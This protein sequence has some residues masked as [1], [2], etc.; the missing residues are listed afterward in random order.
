MNKKSSDNAFRRIPTEEAF[1]VP[2]QMDA[3]RKV[4]AEASDYHPDLYL[5]S[6]TLGGGVIHDRLLDLDGER[7]NIMD[8][9][10]I[11]MQLLSLTSTGV[12]MMDADTANAVA[13]TANDQLADAIGRHPG[14]YAGLATVAPQSPQAAAK[15]V[16]RA[17]SELNLNGI[18]INSH[19]DGEFLSEEKYWPILEAIEA[20]RAALYIHPRCPGPLHAAAYREDHLEFATWGYAAETGLHALR[21]ITGGVFDQFPKLNVVLGH[22]GEGIPYWFYRIDDRIE[23]EVK[24]GMRDRPFNRKPSEYFRDHFAIT[25]SGVNWNPPLEYCVSVLG[26]DKVMFAVDY[27]YQETF[28]A[29]DWM[30]AAPIPDEDKKKI[31]SANAERIFKIES[32]QS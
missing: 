12:Q 28:E 6:I 11:D 5:W 16:D 19:T 27:P 3:M 20:R 9:A 7:I 31:F 14:R 21:L 13:R 25:T 15:E 2:E 18:V 22:M 23:M 32:K 4:V 17:I 24:M 8:K 29:V 30:N 1:A 10:G 26:A